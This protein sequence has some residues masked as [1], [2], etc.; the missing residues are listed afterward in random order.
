MSVE[1]FL[2]YL[3]HIP[4][5]EEVWAKFEL[6]GFCFIAIFA[7]NLFCNVT[8]VSSEEAVGQGHA[9]GMSSI[10]IQGLREEEGCWEGG[11]EALLELHVVPL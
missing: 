10:S 9:K 5:L 2:R 4:V 8:P 6:C 7:D 1:E 11:G 3:I